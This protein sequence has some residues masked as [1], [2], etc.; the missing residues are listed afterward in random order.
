MR[1][2][3]DADKLMDEL[4]RLAT[5]T[6]LCKRYGNCTPWI[7]YSAV[8]KLISDMILEEKESC[9]DAVNRQEAI[10]KIKKRLFET[11]FNNVGIK[12]NI[13][14]TLVDV[15]ENRLE[16]WFDELP[17]IQPEPCGDAVSRNAIVQKLN[18]MDRYVSTELRL[19]DTDNKFPQNEVFIVDDVYEEIVEQ[20]PSAQPKQNEMIKEIRRWINS[21]NRGN[22]DYFIVDRIEGIINAYEI[23]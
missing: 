20:L 15:A 23:N 13:D 9:D 7:P 21:G 4:G 6:D 3:V 5:N 2:S 1:R 18:Q 19:C 11:A 14:E 16:N 17:S 12:Q 8:R 10:D 22:A